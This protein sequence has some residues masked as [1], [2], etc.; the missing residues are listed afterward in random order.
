MLEV[1]DFSNNAVIHLA[2]L[3]ILV[4]RVIRVILVSSVGGVQSVEWEVA[5]LN[6]MDKPSG[7]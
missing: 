3:V 4:I 1:N 2:I 7:S 6:Q 5:G